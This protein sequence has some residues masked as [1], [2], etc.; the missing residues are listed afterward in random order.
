[1]EHLGIYEIKDQRLDTP[2]IGDA[3]NYY[4]GL[5]RRDGT[6][7]LAFATVKLLIRLFETDSITLADSELRVRI[8]G[9][10]AGQL[11]HHLFIR[12]D[13][14]QLA[15]VWDKISSPTVELTLPRP[16]TRV[17]AYGSDGRGAPWQDTDGRA[18]RQ[19]KLEPGVVRI[20]EIE[21]Q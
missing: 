6:P 15:F 16:A 13:G 1:V 18:I 20:F 8:V 14:R 12:P 7:K 9:G 21:S 10:S 5:R 11:Y 17:T 19:V 2:I 3:P 4:L